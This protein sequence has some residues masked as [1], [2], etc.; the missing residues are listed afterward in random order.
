MC[1]ATIFQSTRYSLALLLSIALLSGYGAQR[2][3]AQPSQANEQQLE[4]A[5]S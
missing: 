1:M 2:T 4:V 5:R 3:N